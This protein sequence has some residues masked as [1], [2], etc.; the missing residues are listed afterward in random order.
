MNFLLDKDASCGNYPLGSITFDDVDD[1]IVVVGFEIL[2]SRLEFSVDDGIAMGELGEEIYK[3]LGFVGDLKLLNWNLF[4]LKRSELG[5]LFYFVGGEMGV[6]LPLLF[7]PLSL[8]SILKCG[9][10]MV[11]NGY[12]NARK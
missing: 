9:Y 7:F 10:K 2:E 3:T 4:L 8:P 5:S 11:C 12:R 1:V 6:F